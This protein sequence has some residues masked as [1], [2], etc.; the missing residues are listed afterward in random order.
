M[1]AHRLL[2]PWM[3]Y[4]RETKIQVSYCSRFNKNMVDRVIL[5]GKVIKAF[6]RGLDLKGIAIK[7]ICQVMPIYYSE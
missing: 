6:M 3:K 5:E 2:D 1:G 7:N 4:A